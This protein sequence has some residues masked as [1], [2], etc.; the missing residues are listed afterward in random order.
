MKINELEKLLDISKANIRYYESE[1]LISPER[2]DN[3][4]RDYSYEDVAILKRIIILRKIG[5]SI[6]DIKKI[7]NGELNLSDAI[8]NNLINIKEQISELNGALRLSKKITEDTNSIEEF[9]QEKYYDILC[10][11]EE[12]G[13]KFNEIFNDYIE[14]EKNIFSTMWKRVFFIN[15]DRIKSKVNPIW[16]GVIILSI[17]VIRGLSGKYLWH[18]DTFFEGF[19]YPFEIFAIASLILLPIYLLS[20]KKQKLASVL[21]TIITV[22]CFLLLTV[23]IGA[24]A[25]A[26]F[27]SFFK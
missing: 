12:K 13:N 27:I 4:Y 5:L 14:F 10:E 21:M 16:F 15:I 7:F 18:K 23:C 3:G 20:K 26:L 9:N 1:G 22:I 8:N 11:E 24:L 19:I 2:K 6:S 25:V 17:C